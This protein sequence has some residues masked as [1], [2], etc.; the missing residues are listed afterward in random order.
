M[1][2]GAAWAQLDGTSGDLRVTLAAP[3]SLLDTFGLVVDMFS[4]SALSPL[5]GGK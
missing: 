1:A 3:H 2:P 4:A 5:S